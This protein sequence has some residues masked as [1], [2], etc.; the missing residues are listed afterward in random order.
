[1]EVD[2]PPADSQGS[3]TSNTGEA[4][5]A[6]NSAAAAS[7]PSEK[8]QWV[9]YPAPVMRTERLRLLC[10]VL[11]LEACS[12]SSFQVDHFRMGKGFPSK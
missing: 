10:S 9:K 7:G 4:A 5:G 3:W 12:D 1:M 8:Y 6:G 2:N 11:R